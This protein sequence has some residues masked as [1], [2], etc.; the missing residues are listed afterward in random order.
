MTKLDLL[1]NS[2]HGFNL[3]KGNNF[4]TDLILR[5][6]NCI[7]FGTDLILLRYT[8]VSLTFFVIFNAL[9]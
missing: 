7:K 5:Y 9:L 1:G 6:K 2:L 4:G 3:V 8:K